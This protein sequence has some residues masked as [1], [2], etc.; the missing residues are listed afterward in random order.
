MI[1]Q[2]AKRFGPHSE[3]PPGSAAEIGWAKPKLRK[4]NPWAQ[5]MDL[6]VADS[7]CSKIPKSML[8]TL[9]T[10]GP[11]PGGAELQCGLWSD[12]LRVAIWPVMRFLASDPFMAPGK[13]EVIGQHWRLGCY[14]FD[15]LG[16]GLRCPVVLLSAAMDDAVWA[17]VSANSPGY[18]NN[19]YQSL[20]KVHYLAPSSA[21]PANPADL[22]PKLVSYW[23]TAWVK[24]PRYVWAVVPISLV[25]S[26][27]QDVALTTWTVQTFPALKTYWGFQDAVPTAEELAD[28]QLQADALVA[29]MSAQQ[30]SSSSNAPQAVLKHYSGLTADIQDDLD[31]DHGALLPFIG[32]I[33]RGTPHC[34]WQSAGKL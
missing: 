27:L 28:A 31:P 5:P 17:K 8:D 24:S 15:L 7:T 18:S 13:I 30:G 1:G 34:V 33:V 11:W 16:L 32:L 4:R 23:N 3:Q 9:D 26:Q 10:L 14:L 25:H 29:A 19:S 20:F 12:L 22:P 2:E 21:V 6:V